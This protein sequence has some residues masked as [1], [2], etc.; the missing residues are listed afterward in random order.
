MLLLLFSCGT[1]TPEFG[2]KPTKGCAITRATQREDEHGQWQAGLTRLV[3]T[4]FA[5]YPADRERRCDIEGRGDE[6]EL[7]VNGW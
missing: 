5:T 7:V 2:P 6:R 3:D 1:A 4:H